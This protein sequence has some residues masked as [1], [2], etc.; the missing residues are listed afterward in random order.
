[1]SYGLIILTVG[2]QRHAQNRTLIDVDAHPYMGGAGGVA[3]V[4]S[5]EIPRTVSSEKYAAQY[6]V[7]VFLK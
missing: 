3:S 2:C 7:R 1:M 5:P 4:V 6:A